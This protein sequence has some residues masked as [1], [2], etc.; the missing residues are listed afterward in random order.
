[1]GNDVAWKIVGIGTIKI[2]MHDGIVR[3]LTNVRHMLDLKKNL[4]SLGTLDS[5]GY[6]YSDERWSYSGL[7]RLIGCDERQQG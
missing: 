5:L 1:M 6:K 7:Q 4:I 3:T 2:R